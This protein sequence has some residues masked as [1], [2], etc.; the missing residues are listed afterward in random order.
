MLLPTS[1]PMNF[2][3]EIIQRLF[4]SFKLNLIIIL[5][6]T[7]AFWTAGSEG[8]GAGSFD[9]FELLLEPFY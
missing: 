8:C 7:F 3:F 5:T 6:G 9:A 1:Y 4:L 2:L